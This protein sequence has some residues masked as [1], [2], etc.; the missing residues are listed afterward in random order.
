MNR[1]A[2]QQ[3]KAF[4]PMRGVGF[5]VSIS[6]HR[7]TLLLWVALRRQG[8]QVRQNAPAFCCERRQ[9]RS[10]KGRNSL[11]AISSNLARRVNIFNDL[12]GI[13]RLDSCCGP[14]SVPRFDDSFA[15]CFHNPDRISVRPNRSIAR[16][17]GVVLAGDPDCRAEIR[18]ETWHLAA[19]DM[20]R[21]DLPGS[22]AS[23]L[24]WNGPSNLRSRLSGLICACPSSTGS[25]M[26]GS[27]PGAATGGVAL[28]I[29]RLLSALR[30]RLPPA[31][32]R[33][34]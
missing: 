20:A 19:T 34:A 4:K 7:L 16:P 18:S 28:R 26:F 15:S 31:P 6:A 2:T 12:H 30:D 24:A 14:H 32:L 25:G 17:F 11:Q 1:G 27:L 13:R 22:S 10:P 9:P 21:A 29:A 3:R 8:S 33:D 5:S 23:D